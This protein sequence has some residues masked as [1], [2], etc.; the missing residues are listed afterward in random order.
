MASG[1]CAIAKGITSARTPLRPTIIAPSPIRT[2]CR[3]ATPPPNDDVVANRH[4]PAEYG[5]VGKHHFVADM[6]I[7]ANVAPDHEKTAVA[8][9]RLAA[10]IFRA[11]IHGDVF[12]NIA[13]SSDLE[14][15]GSATITERLRGRTERSKRMDDGART[16]RGVAR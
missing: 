9:L 3:T 12:A 1:P 15:C 14:R 6:T 5:V 10:A 8:D 11:G 16:N 7:V 4:M 2:N 13:I